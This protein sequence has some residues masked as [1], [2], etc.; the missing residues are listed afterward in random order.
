MPDAPR[1]EPRVGRV[2][3]VAN[4]ISGGGRARGALPRLARALEDAGVTSESRLTEGPR[5]A[6]AL[7]RGALDGAFDAVVA[8]GGDGT[9]REVC[10]GL[11]GKL[12]AAVFPAGTANVLARELRVPFGIGRF[13]RMLGAA[14]VVAI[15]TALVN[16]R[17]ALFV[18]G[19]GFDAEILTR[20]EAARRGPISYT[21]YVKPICQSILC[22]RPPE[23]RV[24]ID[25]RDAPPCPF[26][27][28]ANTRTYAG[29]WVRFAAGPRLDD[30]RFEVYRF[31]LSSR[32]ALVAT[33]LRALAGGI[34][35]GRVSRTEAAHVRI[36]AS[37]A[38]PYEVDG[39]VAGRTPVEIEVRPRSLPI[40]VPR[41]FVL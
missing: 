6:G 29:P 11:E 41:S 31:D 26:V 8:V 39:D 16:G 25:G 34:P 17:L 35:G 33:A 2:L 12:P 30:G 1:P 24:R 4:P 22:F 23:L 36:E 3:L 15:D 18:V 5:H 28:V 32:G 10:E 20:L 40:L 21:A 19:V 38:V 9:L 7:A 37:P 14:R 27:L 13:A